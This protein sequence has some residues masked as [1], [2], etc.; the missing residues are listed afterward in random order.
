MGTAIIINL[1]YENQPT[2]QCRNLW[3]VIEARMIT[4]GF[5]KNSRRFLTS[6]DADSACRLARGVMDAIEREYGLR[7]QSATVCLRDFYAVPHDAIIP[8]MTPVSHAI[9]VNM[10]STGAFQKFFG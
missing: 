3:A 5:F 2:V 4:A 7:G 1:D 10:M 8:L 6:L 9:E